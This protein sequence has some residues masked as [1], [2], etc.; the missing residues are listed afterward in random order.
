M[1]ETRLIDRGRVSRLFSMSDRCEIA[2][3][4]RPFRVEPKHTK[5]FNQEGYKVMQESPYVNGKSI[6][7][8]THSEAASVTQGNSKGADVYGRNGNHWATDLGEYRVDAPSFV[9]DKS[10]ASYVRVRGRNM[11]ARVLPFYEWKDARDQANIWPYARSLK[12]APHP[13][14]D[15]AGRS[16]ATVTGINFASQ[17][18]LSLATH[19]MIREAALEALEQYGPHSAGSPVLLGNSTLSGQ[20]A[21]ELAAFLEMEHVVLYPTGWA[22]GFGGVT[23]LVRPYD[24]VLMDEFAHA[25][26]QTGARAA[27]RNVNKFKHLSL[28]DARRG[29]QAIRA[30]DSR[31]GIL[32]ITEGLFSMDADTP[33]IAGLQELCREYDATLFVDVAHDLGALGVG[34]TG[35]LGEQ[36][37][38]GKVD[39]VMGSF[40]KTFAA[41]G[42]F[43][44]TNSSA[45][46]E[47]LRYYGS[48]HMFSN[49]LS[50]I[51]SAI[52]RAALQIVR[53]TEGE[54]RR[55]A[56]LQAI[57]AVRDE[58]DRHGIA[59]MGRPSPIIPVP[60]G[61]ERVAFLTSKLI[62]ERGVLA[63]LVEHPAVP[64]GASRLRMQAMANHSVAQGREAATIIAQTLREVQMHM[65]IIEPAQPTLG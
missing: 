49:A 12:M 19:E 50:P 25:C 56:L 48:S 7:N 52:V 16:H 58:F 60:L 10:V 29:L 11:L 20:L 30:K 13:V 54:N 2:G 55:A 37:L 23:A 63:N 53:S 38:L 24:T 15:I 21:S 32:V 9:Y 33:D 26:L 46:A 28:D 31:N 44:A 14:V 8:D 36:N 65:D 41:N 45:V 1:C 59:C 6:G 39:L 57:H 51:Q 43:V 64:V 22:A 62:T 61:Q 18:Y 27:T 5:H 47:Y 4:I 3:S 34:G 42:G 17:D 35:A 40:S